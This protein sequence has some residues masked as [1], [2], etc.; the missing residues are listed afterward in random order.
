MWFVRFKKEETRLDLLINNAGVGC[1]R[2]LTVDG[3]EIQFATNHLGPFLL[4][5]LLLDLLRSSAPSRIVNV[6]SMAHSKATIPRDDLMHEKSYV[7]TGVYAETK[8]ANVLFTRELS[9]RLAGTGVTVNSLHPGVVNTEVFRN[10][11]ITTRT[12]L[13]PLLQMVKTP[14]SGAQTT[15]AVALDPQLEDVTGKYFS[16]CKIAKEGANAQDDDT[17][18]WLWSK[19]VELT[20]LKEGS[21]RFDTFTRSKFVLD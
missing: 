5:N 14:K 10:L 18:E 16:D 1:N 9:K 15:L 6:S 17:A 4:T 7:G 3:Y 11:G 2:S 21:E 20:G 19:S 12:L 8:L 13:W